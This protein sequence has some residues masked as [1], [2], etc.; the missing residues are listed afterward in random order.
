LIRGNRSV[1]SAQE[2][3]AAAVRRSVPLTAPA[4]TGLAERSVT[5]DNVRTADI[6]RSEMRI[7]L[8][9][10]RVGLIENRDE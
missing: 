5:H 6:G 4:S 8:K 7:L 3:G 9:S 1:S 2:V 10:F